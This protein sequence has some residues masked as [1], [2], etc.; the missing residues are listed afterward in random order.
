MRVIPLNSLG[1]STA[2]VASVGQRLETELH[3]VREGLTPEHEF[4][5][6]S[7]RCLWWAA[8]LGSAPPQSDP[9]CEAVEYSMRLRTSSRAACCC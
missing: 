4:F 7:E 2:D 3:P 1:R 5:A 9:R 8:H 6:F